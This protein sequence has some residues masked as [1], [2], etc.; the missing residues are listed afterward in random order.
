VQDI[1]NGLQNN[2]PVTL[3]EPVHMEDIVMINGVREKMIRAGQLN[4]QQARKSQQTILQTEVEA[5]MY[6]A[7][8]MKLAIIQNEIAQGK[9]KANI[10]VSV[11]L[12]DSEKTQFSSE[13]WTYRERNAN[14]VKHKGQEFSLIQG[15]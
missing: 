5:G 6:V 4:I 1:S 15:Q 8:P 2:T 3:V 7:V 10:E 12:T 9:F 13:W 11:E 14:L